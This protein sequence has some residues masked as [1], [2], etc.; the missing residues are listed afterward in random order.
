MCGKWV[1]VT[2]PLIVVILIIHPPPP[3]PENPNTPYLTLR[4][5]SS[6]ICLEYNQKDPTSLISGTL[7]GQVAAWDTRVNKDPVAISAR[8]VSHRAATNSVSWINSKSGTE[9]F[10]GSADG[11]V[12][13]W[14]TRRL[15]E[16]LER[17]FMDPEKTDEQDLKR[18]YGVSVLEYETTMPTK[19]MCGTDM[20]MLFAC[21]RKGKTPSEKI[22]VRMP[23]HL[24]PVLAIT[25]NP[26][27]LKNFLTVGDWTA[28][29]WSEDC[30]ESAIMWTRNQPAMLTDGVWSPTKCSMFYTSRMDGVLDA[31]DLLQQ[32]N[33]PVLSIKVCDEP[34][35]CMRPH[36]GGRLVSGGSKNGA[37]FL[38]E[39]S[40]NMGVSL[41]NDKPLLTAM[42]ERENKREKI[43]EAKS[44]ELKLKVKTAQLVHE[45]SDET[46]TA[47]AAALQAACEQAELDFFAAVEVEKSKMFPLLYKQRRGEKERG[48]EEGEEMMGDG[49]DE[50][51]EDA[52]AQCDYDEEGSLVS[53]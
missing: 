18:S 47:R 37:T 49:M 27:F 35:L 23:C 41:K 8:E 24:G 14:D 50:G 45:E 10:S 40:E 51:R 42:F 13:W 30:R 34:L 15:G 22:A 39:V 16:P 33:E 2:Q 36:E 38:I 19:F 21:N 9:F 20:G 28:R 52:A 7:S 32:H 11:Q 25:R 44:R 46:R 6:I 26:A 4:P 31:W 1:S 17:L 3:P 12:I 43:L 48:G 29:I 5:P 53:E